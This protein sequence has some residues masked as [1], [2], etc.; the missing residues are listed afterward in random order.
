MASVPL[1][2][3]TASAGV[4]MPTVSRPT[5]PMTPTEND[6]AATRLNAAPRFGRGL[7]GAACG[8]GARRAVGF[9]R[10]VG[11]ARCCDWIGVSPVKEKSRAAASNASISDAAARM[12]GG[13][14]RSAARVA[15]RR[16]R[17]SA[18]RDARPIDTARA[19][20]RAQRRDEHGLE[21]R[22]RRGVGVDAECRRRTLGVGGCDRAIG[23]DRRLLRLRSATRCD[24]GGGADGC[25]H[26][27]GGGDR[28]DRRA[29]PRRSPRARPVRRRSGAVGQRSSRAATRLGPDDRRA[30]AGGS[31]VVVSQHGPT[32]A[33]AA[34][35][36]SRRLRRAVPRAT[37][38]GS[39]RSP[40]PAWRDVRLER[41][42]GADSA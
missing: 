12:R 13:R 41:R 20:R 23:A 1:A 28:R 31:I 4:V 5:M 42:V 26:G 22:G 10:L 35:Q 30:S 34:R 32:R 39:P 8:A 2:A 15:S 6:A 14:R 18:R 9:G 29:S 21:L 7:R 17:R 37:P 38:L 3:A 11:I 36:L 16:P 24:R 19:V 40:A 25:G 27:R 33:P